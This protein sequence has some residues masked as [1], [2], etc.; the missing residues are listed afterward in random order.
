MLNFAVIENSN[1]VNVIIAE[2]LEIAN[3]ITGKDCIEIVN[4]I[5]VEPGGIYDSDKNIF[6]KKQPF[7]SWQLNSKNEWEAPISPGV[8]E[9]KVWAWDED[10]LSWLDITTI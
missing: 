8:D 6:I 7:P 3:D 1:V 4:Q 2:S 5:N 10:S 9:S